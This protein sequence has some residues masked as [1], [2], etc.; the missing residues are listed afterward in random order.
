MPPRII[1]TKEQITDE[2]FEIFK[3]EGLE[4]VSVRKLAAKLN[5]ST[6]PIYTSFKNIEEIKK[7]LLEKSLA[8]L[9]NYTEKEYTKDAFL[10]IGVGMLEFAKN[11]KIIYK[12]LFISSNDHQYILDEFNKKNLEQMKKLKILSLF[13]E[14]DL[15]HILE[16]MCIFTHGIASFLCAGMLEEDS[17]EYFINTL[18]EMGADVIEITAYR[19]GLLEKLTNALEEGC[20]I[21]KN[22]Y[23]EWNYR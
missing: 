20:R 16:K 4:S 9:L 19:K 3:E 5:S 17:L 11:Y 22:N 8:I 14:Q 18:S 13:D 12:T 23:S 10:N 7:H 15:K 2:A 1:F 21:E 6:A